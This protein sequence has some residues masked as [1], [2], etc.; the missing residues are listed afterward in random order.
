[1]P[2][3][4]IKLLTVKRRDWK[5]CLSLGLNNGQENEHLIHRRKCRPLGRVSHSLKVGLSDSISFSVSLSFGSS[6][7]CP[8]TSI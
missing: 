6:S 7:P 2:L 3:V 1:M 4:L 8:D 5:M